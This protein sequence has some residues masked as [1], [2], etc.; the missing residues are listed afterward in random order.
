MG[1]GEM[2]KAPMDVAWT[3]AWLTWVGATTSCLRALGVDCDAVDVAGL[4]GYAFVLS[5]HHELCPSG[6]TV[7]DWRT[8]QPGV[9][10]LGRTTEA[11]VSLGCAEG[12]AACRAAYDWAAREVA[13]GR[14]CVIWGAY[15]PEF[16]A[17]VGVED[18]AFLVKSFREVTGEPQPP[19]PCED[20]QAP[21]GPYCLAFPVEKPADRQAGDRYAVQLAVKHLRGGS[22]SGDYGSGLA[23]YDVWIAALEANAAGSF[24][25]AYTA[26]CYAEGRHYAGEFVKRVAARDPRCAEPLGRAAVAYA[27]AREAMGELAR[28]FP[29]PGGEE[30][31]DPANR[32]KAVELLRRAKAAE[33]RAVEAM[34][35]AVEGWG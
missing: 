14:P 9:E 15:V 24:G 22:L 21:G 27:Q 10:Y 11:Y 3:P 28:L 17:V 5:V 29:F 1:G 16:A 34:E 7:F 32:G 19:I 35:E 8:L 2:L 30:V 13:E 12:R 6:P 31:R 25:N 18:G 26:Q 20:L 23:A 33:T 4:S